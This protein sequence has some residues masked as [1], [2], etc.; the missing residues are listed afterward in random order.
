[1]NTYEYSYI[2]FITNILMQVEYIYHVD[3]KLTGGKESHSNSLVQCSI[4]DF[5]MHALD[6]WGVGKD[7]Y[8]VSACA[9]LLF[10]ILIYFHFLPSPILF[11]L[12]L[13]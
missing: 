7:I 10:K 9:Y 1:M 11:F 12:F 13:L 3:N 4:G 5:I 8:E 2:A 6:G